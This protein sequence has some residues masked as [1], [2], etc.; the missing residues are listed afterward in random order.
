MAPAATEGAMGRTPI[1]I[2]LMRQ[3]AS[4]LAVP[5]LIVDRGLDLL[6]F[7]E[8]AE[9]IL[10][11]RFEET[12]RI[13]RGE[14]T[15]SFRPTDVGGL[16]IPREDQSLTRA[17]DRSEPSH[18]RFWLTGLDGVARIVEGVAFPLVTREAGLLGAAGV[19]WE[20]GEHAAA[21]APPEPGGNRPSR[22]RH[23]VEV[24]L[25]RR[26]AERLRMPIFVEDAGG[27]LLFYNPA[28]E[29]LIGR[30]FA[31]LGP[32]ALRD[33]YDA[34]QPTDEDGSHLKVDDHPLS[35]A[36]L[37]QR[38]SHRRFSY[39]ALD[40]TRRTIDATAFPLVGQC[41]RRLGAVGIFWE[42]PR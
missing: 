25:L 4:Y 3:L 41:N 17:I 29:P 13:R 24:I 6:F 28:A 23:A 30:P 2:V 10:G 34:F 27:R 37:R 33:W 11:R 39:R 31:E 32:V 35:V 9:A 5:I 42:D 14:W 19:F 36:R 40:G 21:P 1:E 26:L 20:V 38:P 8:S 22:T 12:G 18:R 15:A 7:N 16:P